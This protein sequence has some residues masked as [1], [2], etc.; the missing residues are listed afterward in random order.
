[1]IAL[2]VLQA[3]G[4]LDAAQSQL[5]RWYFEL[6][7]ERESGAKVFLVTVDQSYVDRVGEPPFADS[8]LEALTRSLSEAD[9]TGVA[10]HW[11]PGVFEPADGV[12]SICSTHR[13][14]IFFGASARPSSL[15]K[16]CAW[17][18]TTELE[19]RGAL[20]LSASECSLLTEIWSWA[21]IR[22][23]ATG[24]SPVE[25]NYVGGEGLPRLSAAHAVSE[26]LSG[27][28][29]RDGIVWVVPSLPGTAQVDT[30][31]GAMP[32]AAVRAE[33]A[34]TLIDDAQ[35]DTWVWPAYVL[36]VLGVF[37][38]AWLSR[39]SFGVPALVVLA[40]VWFGLEVLAFSFGLRTQTLVAIIGAWSSY[41]GM[42]GIR[43]FEDEVRDEIRERLSGAVR[44]ADQRRAFVADDDNGFWAG[45]LT[46]TRK[47]LP[48]EQA[49]LAELPPDSWWIEFRAFHQMDETDIDERRRDVRRAPYRVGLEQ[50]RASTTTTY[51]SDE[52]F[53]TILVPLHAGG[54]L[55]GFWF[56]FAADAD[57]FLRHHRPLIGRIAAQLAQEMYWRQ[58][59]REAPG[60][61]QQRMKAADEVMESALA[62]ME[63]LELDRRTLEDVA[64]NARVGLMMT[65][66]FGEVTFE[67]STIAGL[68]VDRQ[69]QPLEY[70]SLAELVATVRQ[71]SV[72]V[73]TERLQ[74]VLVDDEPLEFRAR[75]GGVPERQVHF[76]VALAHRQAGDPMANQSGADRQVTGMSVTAVDVTRAVA[77]DRQK[78]GLVRSI[79]TRAADVM[80]VVTGYSQVLAMS[81]GLGEAE[82][83]LVSG[84]QSS[85]GDMNHMLDDFANVLDPPNQEAIER[86]PVALQHVVREALRSTEEAVELPHIELDMPEELLT[87]E[88]H[89]ESLQRA[90]KLILVDSLEFV[91]QADK[92]TIR[93]DDGDGQ[94]SLSLD[95]PGLG[96][97]NALMQR[98]LEAS[99]GEVSR[100]DNRLVISKSYVEAGGGRFD[101]ASSVDGGTRF[102]I[103]LPKHGSEID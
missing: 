2:A 76:R 79:H 21:G 17:R 45:L 97:P 4:G 33:A 60:L 96:L 71:E 99:A 74:Q 12:A 86:L 34:A 1:M 70:G 101:A 102:V 75:L 49:A 26:D 69:G 37:V 9:P 66:L 41:L 5:D 43:V 59:E 46:R 16:A 90:L 77:Q 23:D 103:S 89:A 67:N 39:K 24:S 80:S 11:L 64:E 38:G 47:L 100:D 22:P 3:V 40:V 85:L 36:L 27:E 53:E 54:R 65:N 63:R 52:R 55:R 7:G 78:L 32:S 73:A 56:V 30:P 61:L 81:D 44:H 93:A 82:R 68:L 29:F 84:L 31:L 19:P 98:L 14:V 92:I 18:E 48:V 51:L 91:A 25:I 8:Q 6:R 87:A 13:R 42:Q 50:G 58:L 95:V 83:E 88:G 28:I 62:A 20:S 35:F 72:A 10:I 94:V 15:P 57:A